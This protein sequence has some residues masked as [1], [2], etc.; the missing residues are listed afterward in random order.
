MRYIL[1]IFSILCLL[2]GS[3]LRADA[4]SLALD[5]VAE[6]GA[7]PRF[8]VDVYRWGDKF[9]NSYDSAYVVG[10]GYKFNVKAK[11]ETWLD[12][13]NFNLPNEIDMFM[14]SDA[15]TTVGAYVT[16]LA[17]SAGYDINTNQLFGGS[18]EQS[19]S[20]INL[21]FN[22]SL[23]AVEWNYVKNDVGTTIRRIGDHKDYMKF[24]IPFDG[25][26]MSQWS[27]E[28]YYFFNHKRYS[29]AA[30]FNY[31]KVQTRSQGSFY[32]GISISTQKYNFD[33]TQLPDNIRVL[34]PEQ[35]Q[36]SPYK[37]STNNYAFRFGYGY[38]WVFARHWLL[39][40]TESPIIGL[41]RGEINS[42][43][44]RNSFALSNRMGLSVVW[45]NR[46]WFAGVAGKFDSDILYDK[47]HTF[48]TGLFTV[49]ASIGYRFNIW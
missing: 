34:L 14:A 1:R 10:T 26:N 11:G 2:V 33:F 38:N 28:T 21:G 32:G 18:A 30:A 24:D 44:D 12:A 31:S 20:R 49:E 35:W 27:L 39:G 47:D 3:S 9:F 40:V 8:C 7:F 41:R 23:F 17:V 45:N 48:I 29:Q 37:V 4:L 25:I 16:Y 36:N 19:R 43:F 13:Y 22:C 6:W 42:N 5:S 46:H 15:S